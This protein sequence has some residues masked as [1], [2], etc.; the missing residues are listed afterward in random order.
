MHL[1]QDLW[2]HD[3]KIRY[4]VQRKMYKMYTKNVWGTTSVS[5]QKIQEPYYN[6][7]KMKSYQNRLTSPD[8]KD[9]KNILKNVPC[10]RL[11]ALLWFA[12]SSN[13]LSIS[14][15]SSL[16]LWT[17]SSSSTIYIFTKE[18]RRLTSPFNFYMLCHKKKY[19]RNFLVKFEETLSYLHL[20]CCLRHFCYTY[21]HTHTQKRFPFLFTDHCGCLDFNLLF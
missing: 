19:K 21:T 14:C 16:K 1:R 15:C 20:S 7:N 11:R 13:C 8:H 18:I 2:I 17:V 3:L 10:V 4:K 12:F 9:T 6:H 5:I